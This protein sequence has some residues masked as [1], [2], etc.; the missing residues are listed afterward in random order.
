MNKITIIYDCPQKTCDKV[1][2]YNEIF[3]L[4]QNTQVVYAK[5]TISVIYRKNKMK[6]LLLL[7][8]IV[9]RSLK[10]VY[11]TDIY[12][13]WSSRIACLLN[14]LLPN[15]KI[16]SF[17]WLTPAKHTNFI[18]FYLN[19]KALKNKNFLPIVNDRN[20]IILYKNLYSL[21]DNRQFCYL[22]DVYDDTIPFQQ[23]TEQTLNSNYFFTGGMN[24]RDF[25]LI[26]KIAKKLPNKC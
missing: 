21:N 23:P 15:K 8:D 13:A 20:S 10:K 6:Y 18:N 5:N 12:V 25:G 22:P 1:W 7:F 14:L 3:E 11:Q 16:I 4:F 19:K 26:L 9:F 24:N 17:N 2:V